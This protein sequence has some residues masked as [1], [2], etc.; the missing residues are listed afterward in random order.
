MPGAEGVMGA[1]AADRET[2]YPPVLSEGSKELFAPGQQFMRVTLV[3]YI[4]DYLVFRAIEHA[5]QGYGQFDGAQAG[6]QMPSIFGHFLY[7][8]FP[9]ISGKLLKL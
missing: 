9:Y 6:C 8:Q 3:A 5:V 2:G 7:H 4:P 1:F